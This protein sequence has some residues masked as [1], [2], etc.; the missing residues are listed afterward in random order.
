MGFNKSRG[1]AKVCFDSRHAAY[2]SPS[3]DDSEAAIV[4]VAISASITASG[5]LVRSQIYRVSF[6]MLDMKNTSISLCHLKP[7]ACDRAAVLRV[8]VAVRAPEFRGIEPHARYRLPANLENVHSHFIGSSGLHLFLDLVLDRG[9]LGFQLFRFGLKLFQLPQLGAQ[10][11]CAHAY[12]PSVFDAA[13]AVGLAPAFAYCRVYV[14]LTWLPRF[15][16]VAPLLVQG[17]EV[18]PAVIFPT[19]VHG[20]RSSSRGYGPPFAV[21]FRPIRVSLLTL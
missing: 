1:F 12:S 7:A 19:I 13:G 17:R 6:S 8:Q 2:P 11:V 4:I 14:R 20:T 16:S 15:A 21:G 5:L 9:D 3:L 18:I 10:F